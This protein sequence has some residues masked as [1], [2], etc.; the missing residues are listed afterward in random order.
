M[1]GNSVKGSFLK[2]NFLKDNLVLIAGIVLPV[3]LVI[4][5]LILSAVPKAMFPPPQYDFLLVGYR[6]DNQIVRDYHVGFE[7]R[8]GVVTGRVT[9]KREG[10]EDF[11][12]RQRASLFLYRADEQRFEEVPYDLPDNLEELKKSVTFPV[13][14][15]Q[16]LSFSSNLISPDGFQFDYYGR[17][18]SSGLLGEIF[19]MGRRYGYIL[20]KEGSSFEL[21][22][23]AVQ[24]GYYYS[25]NL[26]FIGWVVSERK[27][28]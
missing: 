6:Y 19:G 17:R 27:S 1:K 13:R 20:S 22:P 26:S 15:L 12:F 2:G 21:P 18:S 3:L 4:G 10:V 25:D 11:R 14:K 9:P 28:S 23:V 5:F 7:V 8:E 16:N 24:T